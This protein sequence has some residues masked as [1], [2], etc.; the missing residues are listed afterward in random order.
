MLSLQ[1]L[2]KNRNLEAKMPEEVQEGYLK[3]NHVAKILNVSEK[4]IY[5]W[6]NEGR[7]KSVHVGNRIV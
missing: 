2:S 7:I 3:P 1:Y 4:T 6:C 5:Q